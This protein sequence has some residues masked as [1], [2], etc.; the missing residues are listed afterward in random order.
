MVNNI[1]SYNH[2]KSVQLLII[3][4][5]LNFL[6]ITS[7]VR[8]ILEILRGTVARVLQFST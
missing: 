3:K 5:N 4:L 8:F 7:F 1:K 6:Q 2:L